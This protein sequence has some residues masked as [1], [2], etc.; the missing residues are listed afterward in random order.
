ML[1]QTAIHG[2]IRKI[3]KNRLAK[4]VLITLIVVGIFSLG[5]AFGSGRID[6]GGLGSHSANLPGQLN[7]ASVDQVYTILKN[8]YDGKL[9]TSQILDGLKN[10][11]TE[12]TGDPYT[13]YF[14]STQAQQF[15]DE[16]SGSFSGIGVEL[17]LDS[18]NELEVVA[19][20]VGTPGAKAGLQPKDIITAING[21]STT[22]MPLD[23]AVDDIRGSSGTKVTL[24]V[25]R[26]NQK[27]NF[28]ITRSNITVPSV[29]SQLLT[30]NIGYISVS[31]F[32][33]DTSSLAQTAASKFQQDKVKG[34]ILDLR[35]D[36]GGLVTA[37][38]NVSSLWL[39]QGKLIMQEKRGSDVLQTYYSTGNDLLNGIPTVVLINSGS[40]SAAEITAGALHDNGDAYIIGTQSFGKG[41]VQEVDNLDGGGE[42]KVTIAHWYRPDGQNINHL[43]IT[44]DEI[45]NL[46]ATNT[47]NGADPQKAAAIQYIE[48]HD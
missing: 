25:D 7:Y 19:P 42:L 31:Q 43:G 12:A 8:D 3:A 15:N 40:A 34:V 37:A 46:S 10:G 27:L 28:V 24:A 29:T 48:T 11:L 22:G 18:N 41:S 21:K 30:G 4:I 44:P 38:V 16:L 17:S 33:N 14:N 2:M 36:P 23:V 26:D 9:T 32:S 20:L 1:K 45:V 35:D 13:E 39:P 6:Y 5:W 47:T